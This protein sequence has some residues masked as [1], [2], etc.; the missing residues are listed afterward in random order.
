MMI[1]GYTILIFIFA[2]LMVLKAEEVPTYIIKDAD[3]INSLQ[4]FITYYIDTTGQLGIDQIKK[5][6][7]QQVGKQYPN[8]GINDHPVWIHLKLKNE[9]QSSQLMLQLVS[10]TNVLGK[11]YI[12]KA[13]GNW[14]EQQTG[15]LIPFSER[16]VKNGLYA[17]NLNLQKGDQKDYYLK[18]YSNEQILI[19]MNIG[20]QEVMQSSA[21]DRRFWFGIFSGVFVALILYNLF[22]YISLRERSYLIYVIHTSFSLVTQAIFLGYASQYLWPDNHWLALHGK[23]IFTCLVSLVG[24]EFMKEFLFTRK[25]APKLHKVSYGFSAFYVLAIL[26]SALGFN[27]LMYKIILP[28]QGLVVGF[29]LYTSFVVNQRGFRPARFFIISWAFF[30]VGIFIY[31]MAIQG[32]LPYNR[33]TSSLMPVGSVMEILLLSFALAD[34]IQYLK[35]ERDEADKKVLEMALESERFA[36]QQNVILEEKVQQRTN[37][38]ERTL[39]ELNEAYET[40]KEAQSQLVNNEKMASLGQL[41]AGIAHEINNPINF[42]SGSIAPLSRDVKDIIELFETTD[43]RARQT[44]TQEEYEQVEQLKEDLEYD[45]LKTEI[46][47][48]LNGMEEGSKRTVSIIRGLKTFSR[49]DESDTKAVDIKEGIDST[50]VLINNQLKD[51]IDVIKDYGDLPMVECYAGQMNQVFLNIINNAAQAISEEEDRE[52]KGKIWISTKHLDEEEKVKISIKDNGPGIPDEIR[53][54]IFDP[55]FT[56][57]PIGQGTGLGLSICY[58]IVEKHGGTVEVNSSAGEGTE[59]IITLPVK[60]QKKPQVQ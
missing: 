55:F 26:I 41:T 13:G 18:L 22:V 34:K 27:T 43:E 12:E 11:L 14:D 57:K 16:S 35:K 1:R 28:V 24:L 56:T 38:L 59:F 52:E 5:K 54:R 29:V 46:D 21:I 8:L 39:E 40:L 30:L 47:D 10:S 37:D 33:F 60:A 58:N 48:L 17:F 4:G 23:N 32:F 7:F 53:D 36:R 25:N 51:H 42:I 44:L 9:S 45:F 49:V 20:S 19:P 15:N 2:H 50:L 6:E 31:V 3:Q